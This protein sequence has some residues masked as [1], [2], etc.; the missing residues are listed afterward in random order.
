MGCGCASTVHGG[1]CKENDVAKED[2]HWAELADG[3]ER[4]VLLLEK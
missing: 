2:E 1:F 4:V 3:F